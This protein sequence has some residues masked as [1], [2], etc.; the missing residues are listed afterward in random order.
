MSTPRPRRSRLA[1]ALAATFGLVVALAQG[2]VGP[3]SA[4]SLPTPT[5]MTVKAYTDPTVLAGLG[6]APAAAIP[7]V[8]AATGDTF[9]VEIT[10]TAGA[11]A[12]A[13]PNDQVVMFGAS[14]SGVLSPPTATIVGG[15]TT[16]TF[17]VS[18]SAVATGVQI[19][20]AV[21]KGRKAISG[22]SNAFDITKFLSFLPGTSDTL[23]NGAGADGAG[24]A[25]IDK[26][27]PLCGIVTLPNGASS[28]VA[29]SLGLCRAIDH[30]A[31]GALVTQMI[32]NLSVGSARIYDRTHPARMELICDKTLCGKAGVPSFTALWARSATDALQSVTACSSKDV[33]DESLEFCTDYRASRRDGAGDLHLQVLFLDDVRGSI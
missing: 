7:T 16:S 25:V 32:G 27:N 30:C 11:L 33:I 15:T 3:A 26:A 20:A 21:G 24:C 5:S 23:K 1:L 29:L 2:A 14:G 8:L 6:D 19:H 22:T 9:T 18:Y 28:G 10:L 13:F 31:A 4:G 12:A 17:P